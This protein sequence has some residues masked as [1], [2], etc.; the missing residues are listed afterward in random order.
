[1]HADII[2]VSLFGGLVVNSCVKWIFFRSVFVVRCLTVTFLHYF[3][4]LYFLNFLI[5]CVAGAL[6]LWL[7]SDHFVCK[8]ST[9]S[10]PSRPAQFSFTLG[11]VNV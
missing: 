10:Q 11:S 3:I 8:L 4:V 2:R 1:M 9:M 7:T 6:G 5:L